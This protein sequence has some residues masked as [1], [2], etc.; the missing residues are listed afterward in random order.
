MLGGVFTPLFQQAVLRHTFKEKARL[1]LDFEKQ[2]VRVGEDIGLKVC[3]VPDGPLAVTTGIL[4]LQFDRRA[5]GT[6]EATALAY[7]G[8]DKTVCYPESSLYKLSTRS[9][10][11]FAIAAVLQTRRNRYEATSEIDVL[12]SASPG[13]PSE[14]NF[15][16][17]W[18]IRLG[19][20]AGTMSL[21]Q[22]GT[23]VAGSYRLNNNTQGSF[24][25]IRDGFAF[26][27]DF[28]RISPTKKW[29]I[30]ATWQQRGDYIVINGKAR[31]MR[32]AG[33]DYVGDG[34][35]VPFLA[36]GRSY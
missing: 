8:T 15:S 30:D 1:F 23:T 11:T 2:V 36:V 6:R 5:F 33:D 19:A 35:E 7:A 24:R 28:L 32:L 4:Q 26:R 17:T 12:P 22:D 29:A 9:S 21:V 31:P 3:V 34:P 16:G 18:D 20:V 25:G 13:G 10:G 27:V 14:Q